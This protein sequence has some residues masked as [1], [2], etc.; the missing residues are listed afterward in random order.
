MKK[1][2]IVTIIF[3]LVFPFRLFSQGKDT[4]TWI[5]NDFPP[6]WILNGIYKGT[7]GAE[8]IQNLLQK[9]LTQYNHKKIRTNVTRY[10]YMIKNGEKV[11][12][13]AT[14]KTA[15]R[16][17]YMYFSVIPASFIMA[18]GIIT[19]K[20]KLHKFG[21]S[22]E[23]SLN[24]TL[25]NQKLILG[26]TKDRKFGDLIDTVLEKYKDNRN[27][28]SR[29]AGDLTKGLVEMLIHDRVDY[30]LGYDWELQYLTKQFWSKKKANSLTFLPL[31][32]TKHYLMSYIVCSKTDWGKKVISNI[33]KILIEEVPKD[34]YR[35]IWEQWMSNKKLY[36]KLY[37]EIYLKQVSKQISISKE[38]P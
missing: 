19:K 30:I 29:V 17:K 36:R 32:E 1:N 27:I 3:L 5:E 9:K 31:K 22:S 12:D 25:K 10:R 11:C 24:E 23:I 26:I 13:C 16:A 7:G 38:N 6:V 20:I 34:G 21:D 14:F 28:Y 8:L 37:K 2:V 33:N 15:D 18:N 35:K 4:I